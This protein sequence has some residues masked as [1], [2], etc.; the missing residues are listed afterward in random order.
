[1]ASNDYEDLI[2]RLR[3]PFTYVV[4]YIGLTDDLATRY[5]QHITTKEKN[6]GKDSWIR[7]T[8]AKGYLPLVDIVDKAPHGEE[9]PRKEAFW[10]NFYKERG[11]AALLNTQYPVSTITI[12]PSS[13]AHLVIAATA[14]AMKWI[15][16]KIAYTAFSGSFG[17]THLYPKHDLGIINLYYKE[18]WKW[19][20]MMNVVSRWYADHS[21]RAYSTKLPE[22]SL[23]YY[24]EKGWFNPIPADEQVPSGYTVWR[25][26]EWWKDN[27]FLY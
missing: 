10:I 2:Y 22:C 25:D 8:K 15:Y 5:I 17:R 27:N 24:G 19:V 16:K 14:D 6:R 7:D 18:D 23:V 21:I 12:S 26:E 4:R 1:M 11:D 13:I 3:D 9:G 20:D